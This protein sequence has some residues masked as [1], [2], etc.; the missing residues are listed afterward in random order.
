MGTVDQNSYFL[1]KI[2]WV[3]WKKSHCTHG[4]LRPLNRTH[5]VEKDGF[6]VPKH[7]K[8]MIFSSKWVKDHKRVGTHFHCTPTVFDCTHKKTSYIEVRYTH[9][10]FFNVNFK[11]KNK[12]GYGLG[13]LSKFRSKSG[14]TSSAKSEKWVQSIFCGYSGNNLGLRDLIWVQYKMDC[15]HVKGFDYNFPRV[16]LYTH[17]NS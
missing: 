14:Y 17:N 16:G 15:T 10:Q 3:Q 9:R 4:F 12:I 2:R 8:K 5:G 7:R 6:T 11:E 1:K 13:A